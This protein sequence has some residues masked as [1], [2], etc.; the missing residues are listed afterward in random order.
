MLIDVFHDFDDGS[1]IRYRF[2]GKLFNL[3]R[4]QAKS[5]VQADVLDELLYAMTWQR[6]LNREKDARGYGS[7][8]TSL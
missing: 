8:F 4:L 3:R 2:D 5:K 1:P 6:R 7:S